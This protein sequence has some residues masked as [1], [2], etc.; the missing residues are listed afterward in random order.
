MCLDRLLVDYG[1]RPEYCKPAVSQTLLKSLS[2]VTHAELEEPT[3]L[4]D[5][6]IPE[7]ALRLIRHA[8]LDPV[9]LK[10]F[11]K[12]EQRTRNLLTSFYEAFPQDTTIRQT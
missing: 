6:S 3:Y 10:S 1:G 8:V 11:L 12:L 5:R 2:C 4:A 7:D 9:P